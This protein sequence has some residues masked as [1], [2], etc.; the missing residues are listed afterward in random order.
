VRRRGQIIPEVCNAAIAGFGELTDEADIAFWT[1]ILGEIDHLN[2]RLIVS[3]LNIIVASF[4]LTQFL[5]SLLWVMKKYS[6]NPS[7]R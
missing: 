6:S 2:K 3:N 7:C 1:G 4:F 5:T